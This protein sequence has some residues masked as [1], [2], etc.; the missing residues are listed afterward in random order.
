MWK[1]SKIVALRNMYKSTALI[2]KMAAIGNAA[3]PKIIAANP[4]MAKIHAATKSQAAAWNFTNTC[5]IT[6]IL[7]RL[8]SVLSLSRK[9]VHDHYCCPK[10]AIILTASKLE[11][12]LKI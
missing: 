8:P 12:I 9:I 10:S 7:T 2:E 6:K 4:Q 3:D 11:A 1:I 5:Q